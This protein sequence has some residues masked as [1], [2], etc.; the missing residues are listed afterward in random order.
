MVGRT[1]VPFYF[2][3]VRRQPKTSPC[4]EVV[5]GLRPTC[6]DLLPT[7]LFSAA[8]DAIMQDRGVNQVQLFERSG[9]AVSRVNNYLQGKYRTIK[10]AHLAAI[11]TALGGATA[12]NAALIQAYLYDLLPEE[13][14]GLVEIRIPGARETGHWKCR[15][16]VCQRASP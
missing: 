2:T 1:L 13:C 10:P 15:R 14:R 8:L 9:I 3:N 4:L 16:K 12:D 6:A 7:H 5:G 11:S